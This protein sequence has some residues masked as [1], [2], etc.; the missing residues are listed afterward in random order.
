MP[1]RGLAH[2]RSRRCC[3]ES[4]PGQTEPTYSMYPISSM[5]NKLS[6]EILALCARFHDSMIP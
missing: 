2:K 3:A 1:A 4:A 5:Y 6:L